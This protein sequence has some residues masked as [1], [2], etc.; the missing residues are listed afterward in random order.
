MQIKKSKHH[1]LALSDKQCVCCGNNIKLNV[2][3]RVKNP[4]LDYYC[5]LFLNKGK[6]NFVKFITDPI[7]KL[8]VRKV[9]DIRKIIIERRRS[10][11]FN[12]NIKI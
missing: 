2:A 8:P 5:F 12:S 10:N 4:T 11:R 7:T 3:E 9:V 6:K 1:Y